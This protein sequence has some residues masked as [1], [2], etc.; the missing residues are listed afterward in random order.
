MLSLYC[1]LNP[2]T[3]KKNLTVMISALLCTYISFAQISLSPSNA[4]FAKAVEKIVQDYPERF[5]NLQKDLISKETNFDV[6]SSSVKIPGSTDCIIHRYNATFNSS[7]NWQA[8]MYEGEDADQAKKIYR[9]TC[10]T[11]QRIKVS[12]TGYSGVGFS[13]TMT[14]VN[15]DISFAESIYQLKLKDVLYED[16][17]AEVEMVNSGPFS[18]VVHLNFFKK[19]KDEDKY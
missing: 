9:N 15:N 17:Y 14:E 10:K 12:L 6:Y 13:G 16:F 19:K 7:A 18:W 2:F 11:L 3:M 4:E 1:G 8:T 5:S